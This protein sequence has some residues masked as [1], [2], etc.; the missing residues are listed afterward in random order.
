[1]K[2]ERIDRGEQMGEGSH[3][4]LEPTTYNEVIYNHLFAY[5]HLFCLF[6]LHIMC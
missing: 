5:I 2:G 6:T 3:R 4:V 1:M